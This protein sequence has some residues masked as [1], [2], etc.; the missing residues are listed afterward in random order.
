[1][2]AWEPVLEALVRERYPRLVAR[3]R[4]VA[5][6]AAEAEDVVEDALVATFSGRARFASVAEAEAYVRR[7]IASRSVDAGRRRARDQRTAARV[8]ADRAGPTRSRC[9]A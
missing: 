4:L 2:A 8:G 7:A 1:M 5:P 9:R 6:S 3:A